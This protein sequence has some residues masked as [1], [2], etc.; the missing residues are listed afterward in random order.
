M[1]LDAVQIRTWVQN[2]EE[3]SISFSLT[4]QTR[5]S[6][7]LTHAHR[8]NAAMRHWGLEPR[9]V[10]DS[11]WRDVVKQFAYRATNMVSRMLPGQPALR[12]V[13]QR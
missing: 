2:G 5:S 7:R 1:H 11:L 9:P 6:I 3:V 13:S 12:R 4:F 10:G 8:M